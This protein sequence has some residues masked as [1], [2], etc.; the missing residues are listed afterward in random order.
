MADKKENIRDFSIAIP[1]LDYAMVITKDCGGREKP[2]HED[3]GITASH[4]LIEMKGEEVNMTSSEESSSTASAVGPFKSQAGPSKSGRA[5][6]R[7][8][9]TTSQELQWKYNL[10]KRE[11]AACTTF[12]SVRTSE[13]DTESSDE[14]VVGSSGK[15]R[16]RGRG[17][18]VMQ[19]RKEDLRRWKRRKAWNTDESGSESTGFRDE[20]KQK[21][22][23]HFSSPHENDSHKSQ[24]PTTNV[25]SMHLKLDFLVTPPRLSHD[26]SSKY[27]SR[28]V[29]GTYSA[30]QILVK[31]HPASRSK[32]K[33][34][35]PISHHSTK[36]ASEV[37]GEIGAKSIMKEGESVDDTDLGSLP[38]HHFYHLR[39]QK[40]SQAPY[41]LSVSPSKM[42]K[43][44]S[45]RQRKQPLS[46]DSCVS[47]LHQS[48][49]SDVAYDMRI[50]RSRAAQ[51][52]QK[53]TVFPIRSEDSNVAIASRGV[54]T[55]RKLDGGSGDNLTKKWPENSRIGLTDN[56]V[57]PSKKHK[58]TS[59]RQRKRPLSSDSCASYS[60]QSSESDVT[61]DMRITRS[62][63]AQHI[64]SEDNNVA[65]ASRGVETVSK[66]DGGSGD[67]LTEKR[68]EN[69]RIGLTDK[70]L[71]ESSLHPT[72]RRKLHDSRGRGKALTWTPNP[73]DMQLSE[74]SASDGLSSEI[75]Y[76]NESSCAMQAPSEEDNANNSPCR[77]SY[78]HRRRKQETPLRRARQ[79]D[80]KME[81]VVQ[82]HPEVLFSAGE[83]AGGHSSSSDARPVP[84]RPS[85]H[86]SASTNLGKGVIDL[87]GG[88]VEQSQ[89]ASQ[90]DYVAIETVAAS[91]SSP[92]IAISDSTAG[93][94]P[95][96]CGAPLISL[97]KTRHPPNVT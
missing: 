44:V 71:P 77:V 68:P 59:H 64:R 85:H 34:S 16:G 67:N 15:G 51:H 23:V 72:K 65:I 63:A 79:P 45:P 70:K 35:S 27:P 90:W 29:S 80:Q 46:S 86:A 52:T 7:A 69:S 89:A 56:N 8:S 54:E 61:Y 88:H 97:R 5:D 3:Q 31:C 30:K 55:V 33:L 42:H 75:S 62:K 60:H 4:E 74:S 20:P 47:D 11:F 17:K 38:T 32:A 66:L 40:S 93:D 19:Q 22:R 58:Y 84:P 28:N 6:K 50:T 82:F 43:Y 26:H 53:Q 25:S 24:K 12:S 36:S 81:A 13:M 37:I 92:S 94:S 48:S 73:H 96:K 78:R 57:S 95:I 10:R 2:T 14:D 39:S 83:A 76:N 41:P 18:R 1:K 87:A 9:I 49:E 21:L 91:E